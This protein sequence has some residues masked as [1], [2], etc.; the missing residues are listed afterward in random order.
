[1]HII[2]VRQENHAETPCATQP[3][4]T[5]PPQYALQNASANQGKH[6]PVAETWRMLQKKLALSRPKVAQTTRSMLLK[7]HR[8]VAKETQ[9]PLVRC[10]GF[11]VV[12]RLAQKP[13]STFGFDALVLFEHRIVPKPV[14]LLGPML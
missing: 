13:V 12:H 9:F 10:C 14:P 3:S 6:S 5:G 11:F 1:M 8:F 2:H 4:L 7:G